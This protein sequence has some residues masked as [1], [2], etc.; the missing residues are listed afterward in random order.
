[1]E[2]CRH[3]RRRLRVSSML[4]VYRRASC[5]H[6]WNVGHLVLL[7]M[8]MQ[9]RPQMSLTA[10]AEVLEVGCYAE[11]YVDDWEVGLVCRQPTH[12]LHAAHPHC[13]YTLA[14]PEVPPAIRPDATVADSAPRNE[15]LG[16]VAPDGH[17]IGTSL[18]FAAAH[19]IMNLRA[20]TIRDS[21]APADQSAHIH[22]I[23]ARWRT[24]TVESR[25]A[26]GG[27]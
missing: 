6:G 3:A 17:A 14:R 24:K 9:R 13:R 2:R 19:I 16:E 7:G 11:L 26:R 18:L 10:V 25:W 23:V 15:P 5:Y 27:V 4:A 21:R 8:L 22:P 12:L 1:M 20:T